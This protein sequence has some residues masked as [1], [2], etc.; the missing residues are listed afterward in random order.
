MQ[1]QPYRAKTTLNYNSPTPNAAKE[2]NDTAHW[3]WPVIVWLILFLT[4]HF[5]LKGK[6][7]QSGEHGVPKQIFRLTDSTGL[8][9]M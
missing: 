7:I 2:N 9:A 3:E 6:E 8:L 5:D 4:S 1:Y